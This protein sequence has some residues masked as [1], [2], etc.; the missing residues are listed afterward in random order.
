[1]LIFFSDNGGEPPILATYNGPLRGMKF[2]LY[3]GGIRVPFLMRWPAGLPRQKTVDAPITVADL[4][5]TI[6][7]AIGAKTPKN[8]DGVNL[9]P[10]LTGKSSR[11]PHKTLF[12][13]TTEHAALQRMRKQPKDAPPVY[14]PHIAAVRQDGWKLFI[15][16]D[17][18]KNPRIEL[19]NLIRDPSERTN[20]ADAEPKIVKRLVKELDLWRTTLK[21]QVILPRPVASEK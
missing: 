20:L 15:F 4:M 14:I 7:A 18:G 1:V 11:E 12:W 17:A 2:D 10:H 9:L 13:R 19:Y 5:P 3:E 16:D 21:P 6:A 8:L